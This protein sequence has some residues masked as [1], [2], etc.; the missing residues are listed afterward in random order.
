[1]A[2]GKQASARRIKMS[3]RARGL[4]G[5]RAYAPLRIRPNPC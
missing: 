1:M 4:A 2:N 5:I 3:E